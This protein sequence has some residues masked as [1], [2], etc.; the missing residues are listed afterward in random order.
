MPTWSTILA[1]G[2]CFST[3]TMI[4]TYPLLQ[5]S[6][7][8]PTS[9]PIHHPEASLSLLRHASTLDYF[10]QSLFA[11]TR[12]QI[13][14]IYSVVWQI[15]IQYRLCHTPQHP[16]NPWQYYRKDWACFWLIGECIIY[17]LFVHDFLQKNNNLCDPSISLIIGQDNRIRPFSSASRYNDKKS[18]MLSLL[19]F[20]KW[21]HGELNQPLG[22]HFI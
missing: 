3:T 4:S 12:T 17:C 16:H 10:V 2:R 20:G 22:I 8:P 14:P 11:R 21:Q 18:S 6:Y 19:W 13:S 5:T 7:I 9:T 1:A 15:L